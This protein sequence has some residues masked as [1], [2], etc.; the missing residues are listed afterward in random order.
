MI[1]PVNSFTVQQT[2]NANPLKVKVTGGTIFVHATAGT[3]LAPETALTLTG[4]ATNYIFVTTATGVI[5]SNTTGFTSAQFPIAI[6][7]AALVGG[8]QMVTLI[9]DARPDF[10][11]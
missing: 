6:V 4:S 10:T 7:T 1:A 9:T 5:G 8:V 11:V 2:D 3:L